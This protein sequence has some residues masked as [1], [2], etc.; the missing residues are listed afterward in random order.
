MRSDFPGDHVGEHLAGVLRL[1]KQAVVDVA[2]ES[3][4]LV[5]VL[6]ALCELRD[7]SLLLVIEGSTSSPQLLLGET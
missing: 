1:M 3:L 4:E 7:A 2:E 6:V 5:D